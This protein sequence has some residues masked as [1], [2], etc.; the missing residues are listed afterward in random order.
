MTKNSKSMGLEASEVKNKQTNKYWHLWGV[1]KM[2]AI[3]MLRITSLS[4]PIKICPYSWD[5]VVHVWAAFFFCM[6]WITHSIDTNRTTNMTRKY[7]FHRQEMCLIHRVSLA[8]LL[9]PELFWLEYRPIF[10]PLLFTLFLL[11]VF[12]PVTPK[13]SHHVRNNWKYM[14]NIFTH[15]KKKKN[16]HVI[17]FV[18]QFLHFCMY[19]HYMANT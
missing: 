14:H 11:L 5:A 15:L 3:K 2:C 6:Y 1:L 17:L 13:S 16:H 9:T 8:T 12:H 10:K 7:I 4:E 19:I 18:L